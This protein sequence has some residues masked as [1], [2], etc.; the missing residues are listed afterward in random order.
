MS[1][2][3]TN[4]LLQ[5]YYSGLV[6]IATDGNYPEKDYTK[7]RNLIMSNPNLKRYIPSEIWQHYSAMNFR[8]Y[9]QEKGGYA[10]RRTFITDALALAFQYMENLVM[11]GGI[12]SAVETPNINAID[13]RY[14]KELSERANKDIDEKAYDSAITKCRTLLE[15]VFC[16]VIEIQSEQPSEKGD[17]GLLY[18]QVKD[19]YGM[20]NDKAMD[21]RINTLLS[22]LNSIISAVTEMRN[23]SSDA[24][25][26]GSKRINIDEHH[27]RLF[28]NSSVAMSEFI[29]AIGEKKKK[30]GA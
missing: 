2:E 4:D 3:D 25:G 11:N 9:M 27:A 5:R 15:E 18:K 6:G 21:K 19:L 8:R 12:L 20:H 28:L 7:D 30:D 17:I 16:Y 26:V 23:K 14:I 13:R 1:P 24:H 29:L 10:E 22:G